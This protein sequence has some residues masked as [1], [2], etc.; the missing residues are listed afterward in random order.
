MA[1]V[2]SAYAVT[3]LIASPAGRLFTRVTD[4]AGYLRILALVGIAT[5]LIT[6]SYLGLTG[7][8]Q[9]GNGNLH[10]AHVLWGGA[11]MLAG[12]LSAL[13]FAGSAART[14]T[15]VLGGAGLGLFIDEVGKFV[16]RQ[17]D[18]FYRPAAAII[19]FVFA[20]LLVF[21]SRLRRQPT[22]DD[23]Q[24]LATAAQIASAGV[25]SGLTA[26]QRRVAEQLL[27]GQNGEAAQAVHRL[28]DTAPHRGGSEWA[29]GPLDHAA[30]LVRRLFDRRACTLVV[31][32]LFVVSQVVVAIVFLVQA[33][34]L[35][36]GHT[37]SPGTQDGAIIG[38][39]ITRSVA[40][41]CVVAGL[42]RW[43]QNWRA[44][45]GWF[46]TATLIDLLVSQ[47]FNF[48]DS[49]FAAVANL[50]FSLLVLAIVTYHL[51]RPIES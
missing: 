28:V 1:A 22:R 32:W 41:A 6:R 5:V 40:A 3:M 21:A 30:A 27:D 43:R 47:I 9:V 50:P 10:I 45:Y 13:L 7:Y 16:T 29:Q 37:L 4:G 12:L 51:R 14:C 31:L 11:L 33:V 34:A 35:A 26:R 8:P 24:R 2:I 39:A 48:S 20:A 46:R 44:A 15:A 23:H 42:L 49:Q 25:V 18:Y 38:G 17:N 19:Y 36:T